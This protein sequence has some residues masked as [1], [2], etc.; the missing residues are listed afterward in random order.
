VDPS[1]PPVSRIDD[2]NGAHLVDSTLQ[3]KVQPATLGNG[4]VQ[5]GTQA[6]AASA[7]AS[8]SARRRSRRTRIAP[9]IVRTLNRLPSLERR[10][11]RGV[12]LN[13][14]AGLDGTLTL[15]D[16]GPTGVNVI[17]T[18]DL[19]T[20]V[21]RVPIAFDPS[22]DAGTHRL[23]A[24]LTHADGV[25]RQVIDVGSFIAPPMPRPSRPILNIHRGARSAVF[26]D[27]TPGTA[28]ALSGPI[29][30]FELLASTSAGQRIERF[31]DTRDAT[32]MR[33]GR[34]RVNLGRFASNVSIRADGRMLY[35]NV[36]GAS[37]I[38]KLRGR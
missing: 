34:F 27:V 32:R 13:I 35:G 4:G 37:S 14:P 2:A 16:A 18:I 26:L 23:R 29:T 3:T 5:I 10:R 19:T 30:R 24:F 17:R 31:I 28:G 33:G 1:G 9:D 21:G 6:F 11:L 20:S 15:L 12:V 7:G 22:A 38:G 25:P 8:S 36:A